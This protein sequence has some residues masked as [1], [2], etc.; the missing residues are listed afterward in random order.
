MKILPEELSELRHKPN[1]A[2]PIKWA[3]KG[4]VKDLKYAR[5]LSFYLLKREK[6]D[7]RPLVRLYEKAISPRYDRP[8][9][10]FCSFDKD[11]VVRENVYYYLN[12]LMLAGFDIVFIS[13]SSMISG[14]DLEKLSRCCIAII[15]RENKGY[16]FYGWKTALEKYPEYREH[17]GLLLANDSVLGPLFSIDNIIARLEGSE[18]DIVGMTDSFRFYPHLQSYFLYCKKKAVSSDEFLRFFAEIEVLE[19]KLAIVRRYEV[20]FSRFLSRRFRLAALYSLGQVLAPTD[21][22]QRPLQWVESTFHLWKP[23]ITEFGFP[24]LK[25][26]MLTRRG[27]SLGEVSAVLAE[28][29]SS[30]ETEILNDWMLPRG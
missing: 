7:E 12:A 18:A 13:S 26:S 11:S 9:C 20:G 24:F 21:Y 19:F 30:Y 10:L 22:H 1:R 2:L 29:G 15:N 16:D 23:L 28:A 17:S 3:V 25:K 8:V 6:A 5:D 14:S 27:V 4:V